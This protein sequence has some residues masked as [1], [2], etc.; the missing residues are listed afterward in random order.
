[1]QQL[2]DFLRQN[3][4]ILLILVMWLVGLAGKVL[5]GVGQRA[6]QAARRSAE[7]LARRRAAGQAP[8]PPR[9]QQTQLPA[10]QTKAPP[11]PAGR[12]RPMTQEEAIAEM[13][14]ILAGE[15]PA[16]R[17]EP[18]PQPRPEPRPE[19]RR[20]RPMR[21]EPA[22]GDAARGGRLSQME[23]HVDPHVGERM[24]RRQSPSSGRV[25]HTGLGGLG[26]REKRAG[27]RRAARVGLLDLDDLKRAIVVREVLGPPVALR[28][29]WG[30][31]GGAGRVP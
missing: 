28:E 22:S 13:R 31:P 11:T 1:M 7:E 19:P 12:G 9:P 20:Q 3:P 25:G 15:A 30:E 14:R 21:Q 4:I 16:G 26:G 23:V 27:P 24:Q 17:P 29:G 5:Q 2:W 10:M 18:K 8:Q 6:Q